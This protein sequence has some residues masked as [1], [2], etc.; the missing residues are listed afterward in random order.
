[1]R[2][3]VCGRL[4]H[5]CFVAPPPGKSQQI[6][7]PVDVFMR[8][9]SNRSG[10]VGNYPAASNTEQT[11]AMSFIQATTELISRH[12]EAT[13]FCY[14]IFLPIC[15]HA[16]YMSAKAVTRLKNRRELDKETPER[17][18]LRE[19]VDQIAKEPSPSLA[20]LTK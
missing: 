20:K 17:R 16:G 12:L 10:P 3:E 13:I 18:K 5:L 2:K 9:M 19:L 1:M 11:S 14:L 15:Y 7:R 8:A 4:F 6:R